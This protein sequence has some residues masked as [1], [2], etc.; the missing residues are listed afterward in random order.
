M[1]SP[2]AT[3][4]LALPRFFGF[5]TGW[6]PL[7]ALWGAKVMCETNCFSVGNML[8]SVPYS[9]R[10]N[11]TVSTPIAS[12]PVHAGGKSS[13]QSVD[14]AISQPPQLWRPNRSIRDADCLLHLRQPGRADLPGVPRGLPDNHLHVGRHGAAHRQWLR[15][16]RDLNAR[17]HCLGY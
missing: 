9:L 7:M 13:Q 3:R 12:I 15:L 2:A 1:R 6:P 5:F 14:L 11:W 16:R 8:K 17:N 10:T 4:L